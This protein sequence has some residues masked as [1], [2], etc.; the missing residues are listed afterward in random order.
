MLLIFGGWR[1]VVFVGLHPMFSTLLFW[2]VFGMF[3]FT[4]FCWY[5]FFRWIIYGAALSM[6]SL[7]GLVANSGTLDALAVSGS[8]ASPDPVA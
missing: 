7:S 2:F 5:S 1:N 3:G 8:S 6:S 4:D